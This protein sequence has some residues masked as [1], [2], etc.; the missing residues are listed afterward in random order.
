MGFGVGDQID[1]VGTKET[2]YSVSNDILTVKNGNRTVATLHFAGSYA[3][4]DFSFGG[5]GH[6]GT[7]ITH[8]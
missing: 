1:L 4:G 5:D 7:F 8:T 3:T 6:G 2:S